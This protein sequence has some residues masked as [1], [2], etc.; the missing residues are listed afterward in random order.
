ML[1]VRVVSPPGSTELL[2]N[3]LSAD[4]GVRN[5]LVL[6]GTA[7]SGRPASI[8]PASSRS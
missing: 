7:G 4:P 6:R 2:V 1:H 5:L 8:R 3:K